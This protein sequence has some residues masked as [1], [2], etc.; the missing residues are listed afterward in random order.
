MS[1][2]LLKAANESSSPERG[3]PVDGVGHGIVDVDP[4]TVGD[5]VVTSGLPA[6]LVLASL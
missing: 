6:C 1:I 4:A 2:C 3:L 5:H